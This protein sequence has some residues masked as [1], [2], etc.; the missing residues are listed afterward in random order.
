MKLM[1][2]SFYLNGH[3]NKI[4]STIFDVRS[5]LKKRQGKKKKNCTKWKPSAMTFIQ[6]SRYSISK[7]VS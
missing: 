1:L 6:Q 4:S 7:R 5:T 2:S 3:T